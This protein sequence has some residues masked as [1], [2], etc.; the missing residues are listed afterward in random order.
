MLK[1][2]KTHRFEPD[3]WGKSGDIFSTDKNLEILKGKVETGSFLVVE[4]W[5]YRGSRCPDRFVIEDFENFVD[6]LK[7]NAIAGDIIEV[8]DLSDAWLKKEVFLSGK[9]PDESGEIPEK[10]AY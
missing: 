9:C 6:Y 4:H 1:F 10:G 3:N 5:H 2:S 8:F 7:E